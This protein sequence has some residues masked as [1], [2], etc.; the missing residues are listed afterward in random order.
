VWKWPCRSWAPSP[1]FFTSKLYWRSSWRRRWR[2]PH[3]HALSSYAGSA[4]GLTARR[5]SRARVCVCAAT[6][7][8]RIMCN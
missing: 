6:T 2:W 7:M 5:R 8:L 4:E 1:V 3:Y